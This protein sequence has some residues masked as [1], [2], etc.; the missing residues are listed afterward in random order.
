M[1]SSDDTLLRLQDFVAWARVRRPLQQDAWIDEKT[2]ECVALGIERFLDGKKNPWPKMQG[3]KPKPD[4]MWE[5]YWLTNFAD[6]NAPHMPQHKEQGGAYVIVGERLNLSAGAVETHVRNARKLLDAGE[7]ERD[8][9]RWLNENVYGQK[10]L[11]AALFAPGDPLGE[12]ERKLRD[13]AGVKTRCTSTK[14][15]RARL[16]PVVISGESDSN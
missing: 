15:E 11:T 12:S 10:G 4:V 7:G 8:F 3:N 16:K 13:A 5:C 6:R 9:L 14:A 1:K 2:V